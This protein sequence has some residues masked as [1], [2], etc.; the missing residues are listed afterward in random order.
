MSFTRL[1]SINGLSP[2]EVP[3]EELLR[4]LSSE[5]D[6][7]RKTL[8]WFRESKWAPKPKKK[9]GGKPVSKTATKMRKAGVTVDQLEAALAAIEQEIKEIK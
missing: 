8:Q 5:R 7:V 9:K 1:I 4:R 6:R 2:S 3:R